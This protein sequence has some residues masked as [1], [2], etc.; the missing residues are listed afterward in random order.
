MHA[1]PNQDMLK[2]LFLRGQ[3][4]KLTDTKAAQRYFWSG[5]GAVIVCS[6]KEELM[7]NVC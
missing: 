5:A 1:S 6:R 7:G 3:H 4:Q 2:T